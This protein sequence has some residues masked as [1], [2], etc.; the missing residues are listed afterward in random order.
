MRTAGMDM[1]APPL[2]PLPV[3]ESKLGRDRPIRLV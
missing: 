3:G 2:L 1:L